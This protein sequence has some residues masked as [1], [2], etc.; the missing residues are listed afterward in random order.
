[1][2]KMKK[3]QKAK[4]SISA[5]NLPASDW[6][7]LKAVAAVRAKDGGRASVSAV[8]AK[9][10]SDHRQSLLYVAGKHLRTIREL[11]PDKDR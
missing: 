11:E 2:T 6:A 1:M 7:L 8:I 10:I 9:L 4:Q 3:N 5:I